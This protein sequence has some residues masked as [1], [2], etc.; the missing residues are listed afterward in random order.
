MSFHAP[1]LL[2]A[3]LAVPAGAWAYIRFACRER[4]AA[5]AFTA[6]PVAPSV[7]PRPAR[8]RRHAPVALYAMALAAL[9][10]SLARPQATVAVPVEKASI[11]LATDVSGSM[12]ATDVA[13]SRLAAAR[14]AAQKFVD[15]VPGP[16]NVGIMAFNG[17]PTVLQTPTS[18]R[19][20]VRTALSK[21]QP[22]GGTATGDAL[23]AALRLL[24]QG[25]ADKRPAA[26]V[27]LS[28]GHSTKGRDALTVAR[29]AKRAGVPVYTISL[30]TAAGT[31][32]VRDS[33]GQTHTEKVPPDPRTLQRI[34]DISGAKAYRTADAGK[35]ADVYKR[36]GSE[37]SAK[38][39]QRELTA[40]FAGGAL[41]LILLGAAL[42]LRW[43][44]RLT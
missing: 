2:L 12:Q 25:S 11:L 20:A 42:S 17:S 18:D 41:V 5:Q 31:I 9:L 1:W 22:S 15:Q 3:L 34:A 40:G 23:S 32:E 8:W 38:K 4:R 19:A 30:G 39:E 16:I 13:P 10:V 33:N 24:R 36:L 21:L 14:S 44:G 35:L 43:F 6:A 29:E 27:L 28:D 7:V 37:L 26:I